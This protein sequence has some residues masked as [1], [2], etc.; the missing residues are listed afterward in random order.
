[1]H[2]DYSLL[3][4]ATTFQEYIDKAVELGQTAIGFSEH[5]NIKEWTAKKTACDKAGLKFIPACEVYLT[6]ALLQNVDGEMKKV[7]DNYHTILI[8]KNYAGLLE[9]NQLV[10]MSTDDDHKY[11]NGRLSFDEFLSISDNIIS[12]SAC[13]ASP[14]NKLDI[15]DPYYEKLVKKYTYLEIQP[16][17]CADQIA[18][19]RHLAWL[20]SKYNKPLIV[21]TDAHSVS[22]YKNECRDILMMY[23]G[24]HYEGEDEMDLVYRSYDELCSAFRKQDALPENVWLQALEE[25]N[26]MAAV[27]EPFELDTSN[28][29]PI[30][31]GTAEKDAEVYEEN[32]WS[33]F[34]EKLKTGVI[35]PEQEEGFRTA[36]KEEIAVFNKIGMAGFMQSESEII[37]WCH[38]NGIVTGPCRGSVGGSRAAYV[39]DIID[40]NPETWHTV[41]SRFANE[42]R[43]ELGDCRGLHTPKC[44]LKNLVNP[45]IWGV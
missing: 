35:P 31:Y 3:D 20:A 6:R 22:D 24:Q 2:T 10:S 18:Y 1:M 44:V 7:K 13:L 28:K 9:L 37:R 45:E 26:R 25:T 34:D 5:G 11:Y 8:A 39:T 15:N 12:T 42:D 33:S 43:V 40:L 36:L 17:I 16:H 21:G 14:L 27:I 30:L 4:S 23:K 29:Y 19:N 38:E 41:F 32:I